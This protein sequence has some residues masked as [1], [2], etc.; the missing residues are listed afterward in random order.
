MRFCHRFKLSVLA[1]GLICALASTALAE[2]EISDEAR[3][4]F[5]IGVSLLQDPEGPRYEEAY[6]EFTEAYAA[7]PSWKI[8]G[9]L[10][11]CAMKLERDGEAIEA[12]SKYLAEGGDQIDEDE[13]EQIQTDL[14]ALRAGLVTFT[15]SV[16]VPGALLIDE[17]VPNRGNSVINH[18]G[19]LTD[20]TVTFG[21]H[22]GLHRIRAR[23][24]GYEDAVW[25]IN[26]RAGTQHTHL[27]DLVPTRK[28]EQTTTQPG[29][30]GIRPVPTSVYIGL[31]ATGVFA[32]GAAVTGAL[33]VS[34][35]SAYDDANDGTN[36][37]HADDLRSSTQTMNLATDVLLGATLVSAGITAYLYFT[38]PT[39][40][41]RSARLEW[42]PVLAPGAGLMSV[43][44]SF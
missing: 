1:A 43:S 19:P 38:R 32:A 8:L 20:G 24:A 39:V 37:G 16:S 33:A 34:K 31:A 23:L 42:T 9:N 29:D 40:A 21:G 4:R 14:D 3:Q 13:R 2:V 35:G 30:T 6:R 41:T 28:G 25:E 10:G 15:L 44:G 18:Y 27:F 12:Y 5:R 7:S 36:P 11:L 22:A 17:R 26:A